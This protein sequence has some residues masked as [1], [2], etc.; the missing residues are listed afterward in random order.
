M[1]LEPAEMATGTTVL[2][3]GAVIQETSVVISNAAGQA[4]MVKAHVAG[5]NTPLSI[6][7]RLWRLKDGQGKYMSVQ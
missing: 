1:V 3:A 4:G 2:V 6:V 7:Q 5:R